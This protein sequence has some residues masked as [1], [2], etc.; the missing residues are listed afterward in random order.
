MRLSTLAGVNKITILIAIKSRLLFIGIDSESRILQ[1][2][3]Q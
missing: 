1:E 3:K 2:K